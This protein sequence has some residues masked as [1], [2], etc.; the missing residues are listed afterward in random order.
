M[1]AFSKK[2]FRKYGTDVSVS[3]NNTTLTGKAFISPLRY[4]NRV[5]VDDTYTPGGV[6]DSGRFV[7]IGEPALRL[8]T[9]GD[10]IRL[11]AGNTEYTVKKALPYTLGKKVLYIWAMLVKNDRSDDNGDVY[12]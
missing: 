1:N 2:H 10:G 7:Y 3:V 6:L 11:T 4:K 9:M 5:Y 8:D 12:G